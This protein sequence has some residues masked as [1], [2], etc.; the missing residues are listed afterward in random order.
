MQNGE[1][2]Y[3]PA[4]KFQG[5]EEPKQNYFKMPNSWTDLTAAVRSLAAL[6]VVEYVLR[7]TWGFR[8]YGVKK[9]ITL[10]EFQNG[11]KRS[12]GTRVTSAV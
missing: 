8:E 7:H 12:D 4:R 5:F 1:A 2:A 3:Q 9:L 6:K 10:D 11:R